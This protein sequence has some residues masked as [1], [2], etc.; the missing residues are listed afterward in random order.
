MVSSVSEIKAASV[1][2]MSAKM[3]VDITFHYPADL[4]ALLIEAI[5]ALNKSKLDVVTF[6]KGAGVGSD[7]LADLEDRVRTNRAGIGKHEIVRT[8]LTRLNQK[9]EVALRER[10]EVLRRV[11]EFENFSMCWDNDR[12]TAKA[13]VAEIRELV[14]V[15]DTF[16]RLNLEREQ[17]R[18]KRQDEADAKANALRTR[19]DEHRLPHGASEIQKCTRLPDK[20]LRTMAG[21][22]L[23]IS[24]RKSA[25]RTSPELHKGAERYRRL[26]GQP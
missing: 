4:M 15:K 5:P 23:R 26:R 11:V 13:R 24:A 14:N 12:D 8:T 7:Y 6:F 20:I 1:I 16:T 9:G 21:A 3:Q 17:E 19:Q 10:R 22:A 2:M 25:A 18:K